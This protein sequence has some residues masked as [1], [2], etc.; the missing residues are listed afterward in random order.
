MPVSVW[1]KG[2][3]ADFY[4]IAD[5]R[6]A[7]NTA[8]IYEK[9]MTLRDLFNTDFV[10]SLSEDVPAFYGELEEIA[11]LIPLTPATDFH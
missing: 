3:G 1:K 5:R 7:R 2:E 9:D 4:R 10:K 6:A 11:W 8:A